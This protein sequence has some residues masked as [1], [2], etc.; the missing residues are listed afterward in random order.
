ME[1]NHF[2]K[3]F[4]NF[5]QSTLPSKNYKTAEISNQNGLKSSRTIANPK[6]YSD[7]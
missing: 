1:I 7:M 3:L 4:C 5:N 2:D 6:I